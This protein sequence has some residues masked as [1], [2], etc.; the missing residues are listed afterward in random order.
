MNPRFRIWLKSIGLTVEDYEAARQAADG[1][2]TRITVGGEE[3]LATLAYTRWSD[4][5]WTEWASILGFIGYDK[6]GVSAK[7]RAI[8]AGHSSAAHHRWVA[9]KYGVT[10][11]PY[12]PV[13]SP[14]AD[15]R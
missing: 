12:E 8:M 5:Q 9:I 7:D 4:A 6:Y 1:N 11:A 3:V 14:N 13:L 10:D 15:F 2:P